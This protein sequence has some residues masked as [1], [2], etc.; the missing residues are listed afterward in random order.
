MIFSS[1][2]TLRSVHFVSFYFFFS[3][4]WKIFQSNVLFENY[5]A[6]QMKLTLNSKRQ[7]IALWE[8]EQSRYHQQQHLPKITDRR[9]TFRTKKSKVAFTFC[10]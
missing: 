2:L 9:R 4:L 7:R 3:S 6:F 8:D 5:F 10:H 1:L